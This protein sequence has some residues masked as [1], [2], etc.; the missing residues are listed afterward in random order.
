MKLAKVTFRS[1][2]EN[3]GNVSNEPSDDVMWRK[4]LNHLLE[5][6]ILFCYFWMCRSTKKKT[7][8]EKHSKKYDF[9]EI[10]FL[11]WTTVFHSW[12]FTFFSF[13]IVCDVATCACSEGKI[14]YG[15]SG[16]CFMKKKKAGGKKHARKFSI[17]ILWGEISCDREVWRFSCSFKSL[18]TH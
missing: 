16:N 1:V 15:I 2:R 14:L 13:V 12:W 17:C 11:M 5:F 3:L 6:A 10:M 18:T 7:S 9:F 8:K 4:C